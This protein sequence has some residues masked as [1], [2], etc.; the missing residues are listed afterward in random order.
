LDESGTRGLE[1]KP[2]KNC[3]GALKGALEDFAQ[4]DVFTDNR[5]KPESVEEGRRGSKSVLT[6]QEGNGIIA[7]L[8]MS[9]RK[10]GGSSKFELGGEIGK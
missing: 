7:D 4:K 1:K 9:K 6:L 3:K 2:H 5:G 8:Q 10:R